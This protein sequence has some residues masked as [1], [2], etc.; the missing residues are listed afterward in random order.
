[1]RPFEH[2][3]YKRGK[4]KSIL[5]VGVYV[6]DMVIT[7]AE[8]LKIEKFKSQMKDLF[9]MS[10]LGLLSY[11]LS[12]EVH[13]LLGFITLCHEACARNI[14]EQ[15]VMDDGPSQAPMEARSS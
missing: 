1:M 4:G 15:C 12:T 14:L 10:D 3:I 6:D 11:Y 8:V 9:K 7:R 5:L 2:V 13:Q